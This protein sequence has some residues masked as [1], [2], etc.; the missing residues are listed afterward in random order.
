MDG[1]QNTNVPNIYALGDVA[2][3]KLLTPGWLLMKGTIYV[4]IIIITM[5]VSVSIF[6]SSNLIT[7]YITHNIYSVFVVLL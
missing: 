4:T 3:K 6:L 7:L 2:G 1:Y 5:C